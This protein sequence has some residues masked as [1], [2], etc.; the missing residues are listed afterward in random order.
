[1][2]PEEQINLY[3]YKNDLDKFSNL[4]NNGSLPKK[5]LLTGNEGIGKCTFAYH[6]INIILSKNTE[7]QY[8]LD[9]NV[10]NINSKSFKLVKNNS[11]PNFFKISL[12]DEKNS[13]DITQIRDMIQFSRKT[14]F[15]NNEKIILIDKIEHLNSNSANALLK[16][17]E[18]LNDKIIFILIHSKGKKIIKTIKS[19]CIE[20]TLSLNNK[21]LS[22]IINSFFKME[23]YESINSDFKKYYF[24]PK[25]YI[26]FINISNELKFDFKNNGIESFLEL[27]IN[28]KIYLKK[29]Y[30]HIDFKIFIE[31]YFHNKIL[32][33][34]NINYMNY[35]SYFNNRYSE[36]KKYNLD[37][38]SFFIELNRKILNV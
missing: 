27:L 25:F 7:D 16:I 17:L 26:D 2:L 15:D 28:N 22:N 34:K 35:F 21:F 24:S 11:H 8:N 33:S 5:I 31:L 37:L 20:F 6:F 29:N 14:S 1:M 4:H 32:Y 18:D 23:V 30:S 36:F 38:E 10:I 12:N 9:K 13:I 19:R 3:G